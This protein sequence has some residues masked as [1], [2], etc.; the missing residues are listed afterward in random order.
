MADHSTEK[1]PI[2]RTDYE[3]LQ[4]DTRAKENWEKTL[5]VKD[6]KAFAGYHHYIDEKALPEEKE[7]IGGPEFLTT[8]TTIA[9]AT[10][11]I[12]A[13]TIDER[14]S[15]TKIKRIYGVRRKTFW[16]IFGLALTIV[17]LTAIVGGA[18][19]ATR[20]SSSTRPTPTATS[21]GASTSTVTASPTPTS[22][23][24]AGLSNVMEGSPIG[25]VAFSNGVNG[26]ESATNSS[27]W[28]FF[29]SANGNIKEIVYGGGLEPWQSAQPIFTD[30]LNHT[31]LAVI[32]Y[33]NGTEQQGSIFYTG[34]NGHV[35]EKRN[36]NN[37]IWELG[38]L[39]ASNLAAIGNMSVP[40]SD[41]STEDPSNDWDSYRLAAVYSTNFATGPG[42]R[43]FYHSQD[44]NGT[45]WVQEMI[46]IQ[47]SDSWTHGASIIGPWPNSDLAATVDESTQILRLFY[48]AGNLTLQESWLNMSDPRAEYQIGVRFNDLLAHNDADIAAI[49]T[50]GDTLIYYYQEGVGIRELNVS[51]VPNSQGNPET[52]RISNSIVAQPNLL[53]NNNISLYQPIAAAVTNTTGPT[54]PIYVFWADTDTSSTSGYTKLLEISRQEI[55]QTWSA[56]GGAARAGLVQLPL[57]DYNVYPHD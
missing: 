4:L 15:E 8:P 54:T 24:I 51:G 29:Q 9:S 3:G 46:W 1:S 27:V 47:S 12:K 31:G 45:T 22:E 53:T 16:I 25:V 26:S 20:H 49:S 28:L 34:L 36:F 33:V 48:S 21:G 35:Q 44:L 42:C 23:N 6:A 56:V 39:G 50:S 14:G 30:A 41:I 55:N 2:E 11:A 17:I 10:D 40:S 52:P 37:S 57:G 32:S 19:G 13:A 18:V 5:D 7:A 38:T 43:L